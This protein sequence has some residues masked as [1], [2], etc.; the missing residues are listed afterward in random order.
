MS[1]TPA[2]LLHL[3]Q[4]PFATGWSGNIVRGTYQGQSVVVKLAPVGSD[5]GEVRLFV[6]HFYFDEIHDYET[7]RCICFAYVNFVVCL[8]S[9]DRD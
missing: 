8:G 2:E 1:E 3:A 7:C 5:R 9:L 6:N 4:S